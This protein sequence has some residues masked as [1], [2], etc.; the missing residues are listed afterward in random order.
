MTPTVMAVTAVFDFFLPQ[1]K[2][3]WILNFILL[4][5]NQLISGGLLTLKFSFQYFQFADGVWVI[6]S[7]YFEVSKLIWTLFTLVMTIL[8]L[9]SSFFCM[10]W[11]FFP[12]TGRFILEYVYDRTAVQRKPKDW[13]WLAIHLIS[14]AIPLTMIMYLIYM[15]FLMFIPIMGR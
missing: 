5:P 15:T 1:Q 8:G 2:K 3:V 9:K 4:L 10:I 12:M 7:L 13:K 6:E 14:L 11:V